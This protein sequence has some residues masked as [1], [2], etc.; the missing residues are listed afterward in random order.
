MA[1]VVYLPNCFLFVYFYQRGE[2]SE[3]TLHREILEEIPD[4]KQEVLRDVKFLLRIIRKHN[5]LFNGTCL[6]SHA[7]VLNTVSCQCNAVVIALLKRCLSNLQN[8][9]YGHA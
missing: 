9:K 3:R 7:L 4:F 6:N 1:D 2:V 5:N 8:T